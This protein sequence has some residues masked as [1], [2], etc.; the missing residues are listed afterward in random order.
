[1]L[2]SDF[3]GVVTAVVTPFSPDDR[4]DLDNLQRLI[5]CLVEEGVDGLLLLGTTG[6]GPSTSFEEQQDILRAGLEAAGDRTVMAGTGCASLPDTIRLTRR[7]FELGVDG[8]VTVPPFYF[9]KSSTAGLLAYFQRV[10]DEAVPPEGALFLYDIPQVTGIPISP[11]LI[12]GLLS[13]AENKLG[14]V[15]DSTGDFAHSLALIRAFPQLRI[16]VGTDKF[17]LN[18]MRSGAAGCITAGSNV[19]GSLAAGVYRAFCEGREAEALAE[20]LQ[21]ELAAARSALEKYTPFAASLKSL[22]AR[23]FEGGGWNV[24]PPLVPL[25][26]EEEASLVRSL[27]DIGLG[28]KMDWL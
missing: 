25:S 2:K 16:F 24:R 15:K 27:K 8:V 10:L 23:R 22:L 13:H 1:M 14:G 21:E 9:K 6:E 3:K 11:E 17:L 5:R 18:G 28:Q 7:A 4:P 19:F 20:A 26:S 12:A